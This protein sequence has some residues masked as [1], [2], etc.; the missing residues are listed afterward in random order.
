MNSPSSLPTAPANS[1]ARNRRP[2]LMR[3]S[4]ALTSYQVL[5]GQSLELECIVQGL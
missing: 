2:Q 4:G 3:P 5:R 1:V